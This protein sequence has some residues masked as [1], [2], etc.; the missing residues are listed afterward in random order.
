MRAKDPMVACVLLM[1]S[2]LPFDGVYASFPFL[3]M[4][5]ML[6]FDG[7]S[8]SLT[9]GHASVRWRAGRASYIW[10]L[11]VLHMMV[12]LVLSSAVRQTRGLEWCR[13][14]VT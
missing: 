5:Y 10:W 1:V 8:A 6:P 3:L 14:G 11:C 4:V 7:D 9:K 2:V 13:R 12:V